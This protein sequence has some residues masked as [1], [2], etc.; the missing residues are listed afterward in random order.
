MASSKD[1]KNSDGKLYTVLKNSAEF[2]AS[3]GCHVAGACFTVSTVAPMLV[4]NTF[5][6]E[7]KAGERYIDNYNS[8]KKDGMSNN[9]ASRYASMMDRPF[10]E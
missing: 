10:G 1:T 4:S 2:A 9:D 3:Y 8:A 6:Q 5:E 7:K